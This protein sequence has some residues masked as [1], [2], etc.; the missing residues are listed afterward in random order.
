M[1]STSTEQT[2]FT[3]GYDMQKLR[4]RPR[5]EQLNARSSAFTLIELLVVIAIIAI[6]ASLLLPALSRAKLAADGSGCRS[7]LRQ[8]MLGMSMYVMQ[9]GAYPNPDAFVSELQPFT[10]AAWP[11]PNY[12]LRFNGNVQF[13]AYAG[14]RTSVYACPAYNRVHGIFAPAIYPLVP[15]PTGSYGYNFSGSGV[16]EG[17]GL[18][19]QSGM[20]NSTRPWTPTREAAVV[21]P[22][23]LIAV[24][25]AVMWPGQSPV[26]GMPNL[27]LTFSYTAVTDAAL[28]NLPSGD[29]AVQAMR[30][31]H[32]GRW[33]MAFCDS[34]VEMLRANQLFDKSNSIVAQRWNIDHLP[35]N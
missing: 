28:R 17:Q 30:L 2:W 32:G 31:R 18:G 16:V 12:D 5:R 22:S 11:E 25:D 7:N 20:Y 1:M 3:A 14:P 6:L 33:I 8:I 19:G 15:L 34:H 13:Q 26:F 4:I 10:G 23:D 24:G 27:S 29:P 21:T 9:G 35:H